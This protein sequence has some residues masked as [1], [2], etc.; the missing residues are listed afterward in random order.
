[1]GFADLTTERLVSRMDPEP[2]R[3]NVLTSCFLERARIPITLP[4][5]LDVIEQ[6]LQTCW[7]IDPSQARMVVIPNTLELEVLW[8]TQPLEAEVR[9]HPHLRL[10]T[11]FLP[12][13]LSAEGALDQ[14]ALFPHSTQARR[15]K[16]RRG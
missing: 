13:P 16:V 14:S 3:I 15:G 7:R 6:A 10:E 2:F 9:A 8:V 11:E 1:V 12:L 4:T 5:D